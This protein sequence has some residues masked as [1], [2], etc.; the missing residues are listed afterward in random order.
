MCAISGRESVCLVLEGLFLPLIGLVRFDQKV[1]SVPIFKGFG[2][3]M[4]RT[5]PSTRS[6]GF[7]SCPGRFFFWDCSWTFSIVFLR[8]RAETTLTDS[9][10]NIVFLLL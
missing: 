2:S 6:C 4:V 1:S 7:D 3:L 5:S 8:L 10:T 9:N